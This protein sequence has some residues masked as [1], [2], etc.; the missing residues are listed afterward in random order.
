MTHVTAS[1]FFPVQA[2]R[3]FSGLD[4]HPSS[5]DR[6]MG[7]DF[8]RHCLFLTA[9]ELVDAHPDRVEMVEGN[10][11]ISKYPWCVDCSPMEW[12]KR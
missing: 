3:V 7:K 1:L 12:A 4:W 11:L 5:R 6:D 2:S 8:E 10:G 9:V